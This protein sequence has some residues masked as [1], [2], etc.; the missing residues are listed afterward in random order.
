MHLFL[1]PACG[2]LAA[3][4]LTLCAPPGAPAQDLRETLPRHLP[5]AARSQDLAVADLDRDGRLDVLR[6]CIGPNELLL[7][8]GHA[9]FGPG[10]PSLGGIDS[11]TRRLVAFDADGDGDLDLF[12]CDFVIPRLLA[13]TAQGFVDVSLAQLPLGFFDVQ[14]A[15]VGD[16]D[17]DG[18]PDL[19]LAVDFAASQLW[20]NDGIGN[21]A[22]AAAARFPSPAF[23][24]GRAVRLVDLDGDGDLDAVLA[25]AAGPLRLLAN[26]GTGSFTDVSAARAAGPGNDTWSLAAVD[27][28]RDGDQDLVLGRNG[29]DELWLNDGTGA[30]TASPAAHLPARFARTLALAAADVDGDG[31]QDL[32][33]AGVEYGE[34]LLNDGTGRFTLAPGALPALPGWTTGLTA[35]DLDG[36]GDTDLLIARPFD[37]DRLLLGDGRGGFLDAQ[38][39]DLAEDERAGLAV[40][41]GDLDGDGRLE[42]AIGA[43]GPDALELQVSGGRF[44][45]SPSFW[46]GTDATTGIAFARVDA[47]PHLDLV[48]A[49]FGTP[50]EVLFGDGAGGFV[51]PPP[52]AGPWPP[53]AAGDFTRALLVADLDGDGDVDAVLGNLGPDRL[54]RGDG[55]GSFTVAPAGVWPVDAAATTALAA[56]DVD[57]DG[58]RDVVLARD[59]SRN[60][61]YL[62]TSAGAF[63]DASATWLPP[64]TDATQAV[65][66]FDADAD[67][68]SDLLFG[69]DAGLRLFRNDRTPPLVETTATATPPAGASG[70]LRVT[71]LAALDEDN[72]GDLDVV[73]GR[74][75]GAFLWRNDGSG[76]FAAAGALTDPGARVAALAAG[77][78][79]GDGDTDLALASG[80]GRARLLRNG[81]R[82][83]ATPFA[84][85]VGR[86]FTIEVTARQAAPPGGSLAIV[87][88]ALGP[89]AVPIALPPFGTLRLDPATLATLTSLQLPAGASRALDLP[90]PAAP[91]LA[92]L[93]VFAQALVL[94]DPA[95]AASWRFTREAAG[96][97]AAN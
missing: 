52:G 17:R 14:D 71:S 1:P 20:L 84:A 66:A 24:A 41:L 39:A 2:A 79:D 40:A 91:A 45:P 21:F 82:E 89:A 74:E 90:V 87:W 65:L 48:R 49:G 59:G 85:R 75:D 43:D 32:A 26:D 38:R 6:A 9:R 61:I 53:A 46:P 73:V 86:P 96:T 68:D 18:D 27:L 22:R 37:R 67:G 19:A 56:A 76:R 7:G 25:V 47:D 3:L 72:D 78:V 81:A 64:D 62:A 36:D 69:G 10:G 60:A 77:D 33:R 29:T 80:D 35:R 95:T 4:A 63:V 70:S 88:L 23:D 15:A 12:Q 54:L 13:Q 57:G 97:F 44:V 28:D 94:H 8:D 55:L 51:P 83:L 50:G 92:G 30:F 93:S 31:D 11:Q 42:V 34:L 16:V 58:R 5:P